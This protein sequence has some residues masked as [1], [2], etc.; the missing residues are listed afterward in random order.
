MNDTVSIKTRRVKDFLNNEVKDFAKYVIETRS[1]PNIMDGMRVGARKCIWAA[2]TGDLKSKSKVKMMSLIGDVMKLHY[3][4]GDSS[5]MNTIV[6]LSSD[7]VFRYKPF[8]VIGQ[9]GSLRETKCD[10]APRYLTI[11]KSEYIDLFTTDKELLEIQEDEG[12]KIEPKYFLPLVPVV[13]LY[14]TNSPGYGF[15]FRSFAYTLDSVIDNCIHALNDESC[16]DEEF[17][18][19]PDIEGINPDNLIFN[20][21]KNCWYNV[22]C[23]KIDEQQNTLTVTDLPYDIQL[24]K[25]EEHLQ[26]LV[27]KGIISKVVNLS[28]D[29]NI[30]YII[31][32]P[33]GRLRVIYNE[34]KWKF[35]QTFKLFSKVSKD[36]L[37]CMDIDGR[38]I[39][40]FDSAYELID[41]FVKR[42]LKFISARK[43][44]TI[45]ILKEQIQ[46]LSEKILFIQLVNDGKIV[47]NKRPIA[48]IKKD[49]DKYKLPY[50]VLKLRIERLTKEEIEKYNQEIVELKDYLDYIERTDEKTM[51][52][53]DLIEL[54]SKFCEIKKINK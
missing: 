44:R 14:R 19:I 5:L 29:G 3:N 34:N 18:L 31:H 49:L 21:N 24:S 48:D 25:Y 9:I 4:H 40:R 39:L 54:K 8:E 47:I 11:K 43:T 15:S 50:E 38:T 28:I 13:L 10:T 42:R 33:Y 6:S 41:L 45:R 12:E 1:C 20:A 51:Y 17:R 36:T 27:E 30:K 26:T 23:Y 35:F 52:L 22:G 37:N 7:Y 2:L 53:N 32:F 16:Q 46:E